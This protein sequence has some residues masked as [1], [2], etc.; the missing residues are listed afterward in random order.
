MIGSA[1]RFTACLAGRLNRIPSVKRPA[2]G[3]LQPTRGAAVCICTQPARLH[4]NRMSLTLRR[5]RRNSSARL[6]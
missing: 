2:S 6:A 4:N 5:L 1:A 3:T